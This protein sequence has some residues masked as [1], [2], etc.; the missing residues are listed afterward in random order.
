MS[1]EWELITGAV[2]Q[3][4]RNFCKVF[5]VE[6]NLKQALEEE[7][8]ISRAVGG[9]WSGREGGNCG[10]SNQFGVE[11]VNLDSEGDESTQRRFGRADEN[12]DILRSQSLRSS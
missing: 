9:S 4:G 1:D 5:F 7:R 10:S 6:V 12:D 3:G 8:L 2:V 11:D